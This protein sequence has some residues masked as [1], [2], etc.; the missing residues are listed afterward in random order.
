MVG[1][2]AI[3]SKMQPRESGTSRKLREAGLP[4]DFCKQFPDNSI[5]GGNASSTLT[6]STGSEP[7]DSPVEVK[8]PPPRSKPE[9]RKVLL[10]TQP[11]NLWLET[12]S[13]RKEAFGTMVADFIV[14]NPTEYRFKDFEITCTHAAPSGTVIDSNTRTIYE[15]VEPRSIKRAPNVDMGFIHSQAVRSVCKITDLVVLLP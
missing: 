14:H 12:T 9:I 1:L 4:P 8:S 10:Q 5:C 6:P 11:L 2:I 13:G 15:I 3:T 7:V